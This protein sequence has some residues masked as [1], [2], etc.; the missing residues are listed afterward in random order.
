MDVIK[1]WSGWGKGVYPARFV[2]EQRVSMKLQRDLS[3]SSLP[4]QEAYEVDK[5]GKG[6]ETTD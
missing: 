1:V 2:A 3:L 6:E 4:L 5:Q